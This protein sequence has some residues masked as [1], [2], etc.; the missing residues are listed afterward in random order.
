MNYS[1]TL[2]SHTHYPISGLSYLISW[3][4]MFLATEKPAWTK[5]RLIVLN[6]W[7]HKHAYFAEDALTGSWAE[8]GGVRLHANG[9]RP[10]EMPVIKFAQCAT[11]NRGVK[12]LSCCTWCSHQFFQFIHCWLH[13][14][15]RCLGD[16]VLG[17]RT[18]PPTQDVETCFSRDGVVPS[19]GRDETR[20]NETETNYWHFSKTSGDKIV[21]GD[22]TVSPVCRSPNFKCCM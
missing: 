19:P 8:R 21:N 14:L 22:V 2:L 15:R 11:R 12:L 17:V 7:P 1:T 20:Q 6:C 9:R 3:S 16:A 13:I 5:F 10:E 4:Q 18:R